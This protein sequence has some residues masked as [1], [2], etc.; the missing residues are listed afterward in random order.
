MNYISRYYRWEGYSSN[1]S[2]KYLVELDKICLERGLGK[3]ATI[4]GRY[5][6]MDRNRKWDR[7]QRAYYLFEKNMGEKISNLSPS[8]NSILPKRYHRR[9]YGTYCHKPREGRT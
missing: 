1:S 6:A 5:F 8:N 7:T 9:I 3:I 4:V 2:L